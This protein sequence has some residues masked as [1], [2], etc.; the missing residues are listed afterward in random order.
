M[1]PLSVVCGLQ[2]LQI[3][4]LQR[5]LV[6]DR[7]MI[8]P[9]LLN[10]SSGMRSSSVNL[11]YTLHASR[12]ACTL[13]CAS[14]QPGNP[15]SSEQGER[16]RIHPYYSLLIVSI[17]VPYP[18]PAYPPKGPYEERCSIKR[19]KPR[20]ILAWPCAPHR[21]PGERSRCGRSE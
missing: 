2:V 21:W 5:N 6:L 4:L 16:R 19:H 20:C 12:E 10:R 1:Y 17:K 15:E 8:T 11:P 14:L 9:C 13:C 3:Q 18:P 7:V